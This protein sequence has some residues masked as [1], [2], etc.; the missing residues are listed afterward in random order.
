MAYISSAEVQQKR[1]QIKELFPAKQGWKFSITRRDHSCLD[2]TI[3]K[4]PLNLLDGAKGEERGYTQVNHFYLEG[5]KHQEILQKIVNV[6][7]HGNFDKSDLMA[8]YHH[9][10][11]Y[12][13]L[14]IGDYNK[15]F[16]VLELK[17]KNEVSKP[18]ESIR[19][20][21]VFSV[22][23]LK[24]TYESKQK[25]LNKISESEHAYDIIKPF[26]KD[27]IDYREEMFAVYLNRANKVVA[28][29]LIATGGTCSVQVDVKH[30]AQGAIL[31]NSVGVI[32]AHNHPSG[33]MQASHE[34]D[35]LTKKVKEGLKLLDIQLLDHLILTSDGYLSYADL[36]KI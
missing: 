13:H 16:E 23:E 26:F 27:C 14:S 9:V 28:A 19:Y 3:L 32:L 24:V 7:M 8:D 15:P 22:G 20:R 33:N 12:F 1:N 11:F 34:D 17:P 4:A 36:G 35:A 6:C 29:H 25:A 2:V 18:I 10:G 5:Y 21:E 31:S 30:I